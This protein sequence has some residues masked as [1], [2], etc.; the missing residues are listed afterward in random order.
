MKEEK[1]GSPIQ[2]VHQFGESELSGLR[3]FVD[4][5]LKL[6]KKGSRTLF[7][8]RTDLVQVTGKNHRGLLVEK[9]EG[10]EGGREGARG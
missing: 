8:L 9:K 5:C 3:Q 7:V 6:V 1:E 10:R 2:V 4:M